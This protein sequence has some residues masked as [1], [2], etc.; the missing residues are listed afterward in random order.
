M[1]G[2]QSLIW[3][4]AILYQILN[5]FVDAFFESTSGITTTGATV[6]ENLEAKSHGILIWRALLQ[7]LGGVGI[8]VMALAVLPMLSIGGMQ[9]FKTSHMNPDKVV[10]K[11]TSLLQELI[12]FI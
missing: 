12:L 7:W 2:S 8:I 1:H 9:L 6:I 11:A 3:I 10:P 4:I 5:E